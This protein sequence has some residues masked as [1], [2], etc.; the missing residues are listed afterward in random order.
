MYLNA[1][2]LAQIAVLII[3]AL[4]TMKFVWPPIVK[5]LDDR[6]AKISDGLARAERGRES[7]AASAKQSAELVREGRE[8]AAETIALAEKRA[9]EIIEKAKEDARVEAEKVIAAAQ[10]EIEQDALRMR[11]ALRGRVA[12]LAVAGAEKILRREVD[13]KA[14]AELLAAIGQEL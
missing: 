2:L 4:F 11:D 5:A 6:A 3:L 1:T 10:A 9:G 13:A 8:K 7:L 14:H 12:D